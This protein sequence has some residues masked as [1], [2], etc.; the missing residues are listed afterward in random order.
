MHLKL[1]RPEVLASSVRGLNFGGSPNNSNDTNRIDY[2]TISTTG[3]ATD[4][5]D[6]TQAGRYQSGLSNSTRGVIHEADYPSGLQLFPL[7]QPQAQEMLKILET[8]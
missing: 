4:F 6:L 5:G 2:I 1:V 7:L 8:L 3:N